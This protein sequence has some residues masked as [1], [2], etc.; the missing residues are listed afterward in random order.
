MFIAAPPPSEASARLFDSMA[1]SEGFV[2]NLTQAWAWRP[3]VYEGF[4]A[5][6]NQLTA[7]AALT[8]RDKAVIVCATAAQ[9]GDSYCALA[10]GRS[11]SSEAGASAAAAVIGDKSNE[12]LTARD[13]ALAAWARKVV[14]NPNGTT[15]ADVQALRDAGFGDREIFEITAFV[16]FRIAFSTVNDALGLNPDWQLA[17]A[18]P[19]TVRSAV[20][21][22]RPVSEKPASA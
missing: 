13:R 1:K 6:R 19:Q 4:G 17:Q 21:F 7:A 10:W 2:M 20:H 15:A 9:L 5:L 22:G 8:Q 12:A 11:L 18:L 3:D 14:A 16:A